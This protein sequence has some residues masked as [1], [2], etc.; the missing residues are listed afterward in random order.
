MKNIKLA[1]TG[2]LN[3][4]GSFQEKV[5]N[6]KEIFSDEILDLLKGCDYCI[7]NLEGPVT[8]AKAIST[9]KT[10]VISPPGTITY[11][12]KRN[13]KLFNLANNHIF[14]AGKQGFTDTLSEIDKN[15]CL[16]FG[17]W[18]NTNNIE[19]KLL[20]NDLNIL[21]Y[22]EKQK[23]NNKSLILG[24]KKHLPKK[25]QEIDILF[26]H[27]GEEFS[28]YPSKTKRNHLKK[29]RAKYN[30]KFIIS[31]HSHTL[32]GSEKI[33]NTS[34]FYSLGNFIFDI[35]QHYYHHYTNE[36]AILILNR[37]N[38]KFSYELFPI[39]IDRKKGTVEKGNIDI[40]KRYEQYSAFTS[41]N[42]KWRKEAYR[43]LFDR[44][45]IPQEL[46]QNNDSLQKKSVFSL[47]LSL[48]FYRKAFRFIFDNN[49]RSL[50]WNAFIYKIF[51]S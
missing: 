19:N 21:S 29:I 33:N 37:I 6:N 22:T 4:S 24:I 8:S 2:D 5:L 43:T 42:K 45:P 51:K 41:Y 46:L 12:A 49:N 10:N 20:I 36:S 44:K 48:N 9:D 26:H 30:P 25:N 27:G 28:L 16:H 34:I 38:G 39:H 11:L 1:I 13:I 14:D 31:H 50:Y 7:T 32:Q 15:N 17:A 47:F 3:I 23:Q 18:L 35:P 40:I